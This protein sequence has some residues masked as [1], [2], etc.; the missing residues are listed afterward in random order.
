MNPIFNYFYQIFNVHKKVL[1]WPIVQLEKK[2]SNNIACIIHNFYARSKRLPHKFNYDN[3]LNLFY[4]TENGEKHYFSNRIRGFELYENGLKH[5]SDNLASSYCLD[6]IVF[7]SS[8]I[9]IDCGANYA[10]LYLYLKS[11]IDPKNYITFEPSNEEFNVIKINAP[12]SFNN[13][14]GLGN[15]NLIKKFYLSTEDGDS[16]FVKPSAYDEIVEIQTVTLSSFV[17]KN[18]IE[19]IKLLKLE[20]EGFEPEIL[21]GALDILGFIDYIAVDGGNERGVTEDET[22]SYLT[23]ALL[24]NNFE[25]LEVNW[26]QSRA[27]FK[28]I[29]P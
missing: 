17:K 22:F 1:L 14:I 18:K 7:S 25:I 23:N 19:K 15:N 16:S 24:R 12:Q 13:N 3:L 8:D 9:V 28:R 4:I 6:Q 2:G 20:A 27:L 10:D 26:S 21:D 29:L 11:D 5:R